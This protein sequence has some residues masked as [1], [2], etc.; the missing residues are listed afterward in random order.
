MKQTE[1]RNTSVQSAGSEGKAEL[2]CIGPL[3]DT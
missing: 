2:N 3:L 1:L